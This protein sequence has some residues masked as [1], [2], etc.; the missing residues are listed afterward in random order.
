MSESAPERA[1][2]MAEAAAMCACSPKTLRRAVKS[3]ILTTIPVGS[4]TRK[5]AVLPS[6]L[7]AYQRRI[8]Q[9]QSPA[10]KTAPTWSPFV[11]TASELERLIGAGRTKTRASTNGCSNRKPAT[12]RVVA[13]RNGCSRMPSPAG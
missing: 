1:L 10:A 13:S 11:T 7:A 8:R 9:C 6:D 5:R 12:L 4:G 3:G 2:T